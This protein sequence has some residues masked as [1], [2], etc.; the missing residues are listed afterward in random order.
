MLFFGSVVL[1]F[2]QR[3]VRCF[4]IGGPICLLSKVCLKNPN[5]RSLFVQEMSPL[6][7]ILATLIFACW[8]PATS[9]SCLERAG[10]ISDIDDGTPVGESSQTGPCWNVAPAI[11]KL[12]H[13]QREP[14]PTPTRTLVLP[15]E[16]FELAP[17]QNLIPCAEFGVAPPELGKC[18]QFFFRAASAPR[19]PS[20]VS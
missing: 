8:I 10:W 19:A 15:N 1:F 6:K 11:H 20:S 3:K 5:Y 4:P 7:T 18:W 2:R 12:L 9:W 17:L 13:N 16:L 14:T